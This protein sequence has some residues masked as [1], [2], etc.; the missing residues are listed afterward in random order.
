[1]SAI[2]EDIDDELEVDLN[3]SG[4]FRAPSPEFNQVKLR[5][6]NH[7][8]CSQVL[9]QDNQKMCGHIRV[10]PTNHP[11]THILLTRTHTPTH[12]LNVLTI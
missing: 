1:M 3:S 6:Y 9:T 7:N 2:A 10:Q 5:A 12:T 4:V 8:V 11:P